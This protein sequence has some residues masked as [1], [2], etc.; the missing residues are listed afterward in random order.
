MLVLINLTKV[1][2]PANVENSYITLIGVNRNIL[3]TTKNILSLTAPKLL[4]EMLVS[5]EIT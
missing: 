1:Q 4:I 2:V 5:G 3:S